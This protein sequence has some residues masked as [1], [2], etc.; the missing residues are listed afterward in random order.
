MKSVKEYIEHRQQVITEEQNQQIKQYQQNLKQQTIQYHQIIDITSEISKGNYNPALLCIKMKYIDINIKDIYS[1]TLLHNCVLANQLDLAVFLLNNGADPNIP[2]N[3]NRTALMMAANGG[4]T[5]QNIDQKSNEFKAISQNYIKI[6]KLL[7]DFG[8]CI[9]SKDIYQFSA[10]LYSI[11]NQNILIFFYLLYLGAN[12]H[13]SDSNSSTIV[14]WTAYKGNLFLLELLNTLNLDLFSADNQGYSP[15]KRS[16]LNNSYDIVS[17]LGNLNKQQL[18]DLQKQK[19]D[20]PERI[21]SPSLIN[22]IKQIQ[23]KESTYSYIL[24]NKWEKITSEYK[25]VHP[26]SYFYFIFGILLGYIYYSTKN[27]HF[28]FNLFFFILLFFYISF[29]IWTI[30]SIVSY[31]D[32]HIDSEKYRLLN[33][34]MD[35][36]HLNNL[37]KNSKIQSF[38]H[39]IIKIDE[40]EENLPSFMHEI[41]L[42]YQNNYFSSLNKVDFKRICG[43]CLKFKGVKV[44]HCHKCGICVPFYNHHNFFWNKCISAENHLLFFLQ[45]IV[46]QVTLVSFFYFYVDF[47]SNQLS[48]WVIFQYVETFYLISK[49][50]NIFYA[51]FFVFVGLLAFF[52]GIF[53]LMEFV[54]VLTNRTRDEILNPQEYTYLYEIVAD[55]KGRLF[56]VQKN[57]KENISIYLK[58]NII[59]YIIRCFLYMKIIK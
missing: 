17:F 43:I 20:D 27:S 3:F 39:D 25:K 23:K 37:L 19:E 47:Y 45:I 15:L 40:N 1:Q 35:Y 13:D 32:R 16:F 41:S 24:A 31:K 51:L 48:S 26:F 14:H 56:K 59:K 11:R 54:G 55:K 4:G 36:K 7:I 33:K 8:A 42:L 6:F 53:V 5:V 30:N 52:N 50:Q 28:Y 21:I 46:Q 49:F 29:S 58:D 12:I 18:P 22:I 2:D 10:I 9:H 44:Q 38:N 34:K 57:R